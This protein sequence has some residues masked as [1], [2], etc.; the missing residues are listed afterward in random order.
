M[1]V[2]TREIVARA[3]AAAFGN[4]S[5]VSG[6]SFLASGGDSLQAMVLCNRLARE[7]QVPVPLQLAF[8]HPRV[9]DF[10]RQVACIAS[11]DD[12]PALPAFPATDSLAPMLSFS[13]QR[14]LVM[15]ELSRGTAAYHVAEAWQLHG[16]LQHDALRQA[17][18][19]TVARHDMLHLGFEERE[20]A[21][22]PRFGKGPSPTLELAV[23]ADGGD[24]Q[25]WLQE[26]ANRPFA[27]DRD[28]LLR[29]NLLQLAP[30]HHVLAITAH[31]IVLDLWGLGVLMRDWGSRYDGIMAGTAGAM[32]PA[33]SF[34]RFATA[35]RQWFEGGRLAIE[36]PYWV[37]QA[38]SAELTA[39]PEDYMRPPA[40]EFAG[41]IVRHEVEPDLLA[42]LRALAAAHDCSVNMVLVAALY[43]LLLRHT[44]NQDIVVGMSTTNREQPA[45]WDLVGTLVNTVVLR[46]VLDGEAGF[47]QLLAQVRERM[48][49]ALEHQSLPFDHLVRTLNQARDAAVPA[50]FSVLFNPQDLPLDTPRFEGLTVRPHPFDRK[51]AQF[52]LA[53]TVNMRTAPSISFE[54]ATTLFTEDTAR[55]LLHQYLR[56]LEHV[57]RDPRCTLATIPMV[58]DAERQRLGT[59]THGPASEPVAQM[60]DDYLWESLKAHG[61]STAIHCADESLTFTQVRETAGKIAS[62]LGA[63][64]I[65]RGNIVGV[66]L[67]RSPRM[68]IALL[69]VLRTGAGYV[70]LDPHFPQDRI[71]YMMRDADLAL[72][73]TDDEDAAVVEDSLRD[74]V[75]AFAPLL[76]EA[77]T[78]HIPAPATPRDPGDVAYILYTSGSTGKP[79]GVVIPHG[80]VVN[81]LRSMARVPGMDSSDRMLVVTTLS[82]DMSVPDVY[83]PV[84]TGAQMVIAQRQD[85]ADGDALLALMSR[86]GI[87]AM[88]GTPSTWRMLI[89]CG[90]QGTPGLRILIG[91]EPLPR[92]LASQLLQRCSEL[93]NMYGPT[94]TT[95]WST[96]ERI[97]LDSR[98]RIAIGRPIANTEV[99]ILDAHQNPCPVGMAGEIC[100]AGDGVAI[101]YFNR[102]DLTAEKFIPNPCSSEARYAR[103]YRT[104]DRGRWRHDGRL[105]HLGRED[106][107]VKIRGHRIELGEIEARLGA[108]PNVSSAVV[109]AWSEAGLEPVLAAWVVA[110]GALPG[111]QAL[112]QYLQQWL[113][114]YM[115][116]QYFTAVPAMPLLPNRKVDRRA[117]PRP[118]VT[119]QP[120]T[121]AVPPS[122][123]LQLALWEIWGSVLHRRDFGIHDNLFDIGGHSLIAV[124]IAGRIRTELGRPCTLAMLLRHSTI[125]ALARALDASP[126]ADEPLVIPLQTQGTGAE[127]FC[128]LGVM[129]Y[130]ELAALLAPSYRACGIFLPRE[131]EFLD[132]EGSPDGA[133]PGVP[134]LAAEYLHA[135][136]ARQPRGPYNLLG[137]SFGGVLAYE[138]AQQLQAAGEQVELLVL[139][140]SELPGTSPQRLGAQL[141]D[142]VKKLLKRREPEDDD[143]LSRLRNERYRDAAR[144]YMARPFDGNVLY[145]AATHFCEPGTVAG[146]RQLAP[147]LATLEI[148]TDHLGIL[149]REHV[150]AVAAFIRR[151]AADEAQSA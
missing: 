50:L 131:M 6:E 9:E 30:D 76:A 117:L 112:R 145:V 21:F 60:L 132:P 16:P 147:G 77:S 133:L 136:R 15:H 24:L 108:H 51:A 49:A 37:E 115:V 95:V 47:A 134:E 84:A 62:A 114:D 98:D 142:M 139:L 71:S 79:K 80:A 70:P 20:G 78:D 59:M 102:P 26:F 66:C 29:A 83:L 39:L 7:L 120:D 138:I 43:V 13:Q 22:E 32:A 103:I 18:S 73:I 36:E 97:Q 87:T 69:G 35:H 41:A 10:A 88:Q 25:A 40:Q 122:T 45:S 137:F 33:T 126:A 104:G 86:H 85:Q 58:D 2:S 12:P 90:W 94:E 1:L 53:V 150:D 57:V 116:P 128:V 109:L 46:A 27:L 14:M 23:L 151:T 28:A 42:G 101:G 148:D 11:T 17:F 65:G 130:K 141:K 68:I 113:P 123:D 92:D 5:L 100:I 72:I 121:A 124:R 74:R 105:E 63:R 56:V 143:P 107:Q 3:W 91:G 44:G 31:E 52:D 140:D 64:G 149:S 127:M 129:L 111:A 118:Q 93:W 8:Q 146:W 4:A 110:E 48:L 38:R 67:D 75:V 19:D 34:G 99:Q 96:C 55:S 144:R 61:P 81:L 82:F 106:S 54:Y 89:D 135:I 119:E 125:D